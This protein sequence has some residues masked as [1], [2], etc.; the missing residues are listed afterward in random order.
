MKISKSQ[1]SNYIHTCTHTSS[2]YVNIALL[3]VKKQLSQCQSFQ[4]W[5]SFYYQ[6]LKYKW[7]EHLQNE[8]ISLRDVVTSVSQMSYIQPWNTANTWTGI[9]TSSGP[10]LS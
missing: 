9:K 3:I 5:A 6:Y 10:D 1:V 4:L 7:W 2:Q 8:A